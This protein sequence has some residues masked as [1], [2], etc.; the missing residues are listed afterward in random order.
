M[1]GLA[2]STNEIAA[3][4]N[5]T[6]GWVAGLQ[7]AALSLKGQTDP[8]VHD[9]VSTFTGDDR[10]IADYLLDQ[11]LHRQTPQ[12]QCFLMQTSILYQLCGSLCDAVMKSH[13]GCQGIWPDSPF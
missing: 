4:E 5:R 10:F 13:Q 1:I 2:L 6:K 3:L 9:F 7:M 8:E 11:V 12:V